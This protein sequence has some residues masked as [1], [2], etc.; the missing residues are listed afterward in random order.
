VEAICVHAKI[1]FHA[2]SSTVDQ[3]EVVYLP[4]SLAIGKTQ[5]F[6]ALRLE[7]KD[8]PADNDLFQF[9][10][11]CRPAYE[12][13]MRIA[14]IVSASLSPC[15]LYTVR[16]CSYGIAFCKAVYLYAVAECA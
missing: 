10:L 2:C 12:I 13:A 16:Y 15:V 5:P 8:I 4:E 14:I 7:L 6:T 3:M 11:L 1:Q 9:L